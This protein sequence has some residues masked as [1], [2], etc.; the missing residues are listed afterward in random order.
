M[1]YDLSDE[2]FNE[3]CSFE[4]S[5]QALHAWQECRRRAT[6]QVSEWMIANHWATGHGDDIPDLLKELN[7]Q[8]DE[9]VKHAQTRLRAACQA[10]RSYQY[11]NDS[12]DLA[13]EIADNIDEWGDDAH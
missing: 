3:W 9:M 10:L 8:I 6:A 4:H 11:G 7:W 1:K 13:K 2:A 5:E 12:P